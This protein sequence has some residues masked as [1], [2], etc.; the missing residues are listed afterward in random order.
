MAM[1]TG[2]SAPSVP[3]NT[4]EPPTSTFLPS[5]APQPADVED[6]EKQGITEPASKVSAFQSLGVLDRFLALWIFLAMAIGIILGNFVPNTGPV[7]QRGTFVGVSVPI[8]LFFPPG[9]FLS[10]RWESSVNVF[11]SGWAVGHDVSHSVQDQV[12]D[13]PPCFQ[14]AGDLGADRLQ[15]LRQLDHCS[16]AYGLLIMFRTS[17]RRILIFSASLHSHGLFCQIDPVCAK[18]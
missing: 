7:L 1:E 17:S 4:S 13:P 14:Q 8:G 2:A 15:H 12:R 6:A 3:M 10:P 5:D 11:A 9:F 18:G 16:F